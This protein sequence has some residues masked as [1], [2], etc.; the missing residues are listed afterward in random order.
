M[1][2]GDLLLPTPENYITK[3][4]VDEYIV[5]RAFS[6]DDETG[7]EE[8]PCGACAELDGQIF[9]IS[10]IPPVPHDN[11]KCGAVP[12]T[13]DLQFREVEARIDKLEADA[14]KE[15]RK[16]EALDKFKK[17]DEVRS[18][19]EL[20]KNMN[21]HDM[22]DSVRTGGKWDYKNGG[23]NPEMEHAGNFNY[24]VVG[25]SN[26]DN[27]GFPRWASE[28]ILLRGAGFYQEFGSDNR[29]YDPVNG[30]FAS[31][32]PYGDDPIDQQYIQEGI[33]YYEDE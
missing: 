28:Q 21:W 17:S 7:E 15:R 23:K 8:E 30:N 20:A 13:I 11:C 9:H 25:A 27:V 5:W 16:Q 29:G 24:G 4:T 19:A 33:D 18:N 1:P 6:Y 14:E 26:L 10:E 32:A 3:I 2:T 31:T 12:L 22:Y